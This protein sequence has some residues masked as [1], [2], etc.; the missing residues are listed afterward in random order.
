V[1]RPLWIDPS[2]WWERGDGLKNLFPT[3]GEFMAAVSGLQRTTGLLESLPDQLFLELYAYEMLERAREAVD[4]DSESA[5]LVP[6]WPAC[7]F[8]ASDV[9][10]HPWREIESLLPELAPVVV[11][12]S[13]EVV[14]ERTAERVL[15]G[16]R[17]DANRYRERL[18]AVAAHDGWEV[19][20]P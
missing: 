16:P 9:H 3:G 14:I 10:A 1:S 6:L 4:T 7:L 20:S 18:L 2:G 12:D 15:G 17:I 13:P 19:R 8:W 5:F 11:V